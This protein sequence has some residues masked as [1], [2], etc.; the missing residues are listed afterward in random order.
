MYGSVDSKDEANGITLVQ[1]DC[2]GVRNTQ[3]SP[4]EH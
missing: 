4:V 2:H 1:I 3:Y